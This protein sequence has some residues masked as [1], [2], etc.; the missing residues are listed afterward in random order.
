MRDRATTLYN[1]ALV[2]QQT[3]TA[4]L[5]LFFACRSLDLCDPLSDVLRTIT[6]D[7]LAHSP[8]AAYHWYAG[9]SPPTER[10]A[11]EQESP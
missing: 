4:I 11:A 10:C 3:K 6:W 1:P 9:E 8:R 5:D 2:D 7:P